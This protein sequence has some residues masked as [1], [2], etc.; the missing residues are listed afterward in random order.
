MHG[1]GIA[2]RIQQMSRDVFLVT[3]GSL[4]P[5]L[6]RMKRR[7]WVKTA[8]RVTENNRRARYYELTAAGRRQLGVERDRWARASVRHQ[9]DHGHA[10]SPAGGRMSIFSDLL[11]RAPRARLPPPRR[12]RARRGA[13][14]STSRWKRAEPPTR[15]LSRRRAR[16]R[17]LDRARRRRANEGRR[18]RRARHAAGRG[19]R[20][21]LRVHALRTLVAQSRLCDRRDSHAG[22]RHR[23]HDGGV[24]RGRRRA[25][26]TAAVPGA[27][28]ARAALSERRRAIRADAASSRRCT[29]SAYRAQ[30][31]SL[32][33]RRRGC[34][35][36]TRPAP[37][38][39]RATSVR[40]IRRSARDAPTISTSLRVHPALGRGFQRDEENGAPVVVVSHGCGSEQSHGDPSAIG[41]TIDDERQAVHASPA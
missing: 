17:G 24:Q 39:A 41:R 2:Q 38:S 19:Q 32:R 4:Y 27:R 7:G 5:A 26:A 18:A 33:R 25:A 6:V 34:S 28:A 35:R 36:T 22:R 9:L 29:F 8:W 21:R 14:S 30:L 13:R 10:T 31:S 23:R 20:E 11:E 15:G 12:A 3:Q 1:W 40:R 16:R 37:T